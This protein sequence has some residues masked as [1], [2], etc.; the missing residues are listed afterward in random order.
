MKI[1]SKGDWE[2][3]DCYLKVAKNR[4]EY[5]LKKMKG[6][7]GTSSATRDIRW[8]IKDIDALLSDNPKFEYSNMFKNPP[9]TPKSRRLGWHEGEIK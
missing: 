5:C 4:L 6:K 7:Y 9:N 2:F 3:C 8:A 1:L